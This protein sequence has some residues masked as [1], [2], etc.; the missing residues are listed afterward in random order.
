MSESLQGL[1]DDLDLCIPAR[2][3]L[4]L[5]AS[6]SAQHLHEAVLSYK[7]FLFVGRIY[8]NSFPLVPHTSVDEIWHQHILC[9]RAYMAFCDSYF[10]EYFHH[11]PGG[12]AIPALEHGLGYKKTCSVIAHHFGADADPNITLARFYPQE[13]PA[14][15]RLRESVLYGN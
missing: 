11:E 7:R 14:A 10:G 1:L 15:L 13:K 9:T 8:K 6:W 4:E 5:N 12:D 3:V 2:K